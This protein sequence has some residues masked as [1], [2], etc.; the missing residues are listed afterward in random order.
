MKCT[1]RSPRKRDRRIDRTRTKRRKY[2]CS[3]RRVYFLYS[4]AAAAGCLTLSDTKEYIYIYILLNPPLQW[5]RRRRRRGRGRA[6]NEQTHDVAQCSVLPPR[7]K[8]SKLLFDYTLLSDLWNI[9]IRE[10]NSAARKTS[11]ISPVVVCVDVPTVDYILLSLEQS[12]M[13]IK[14]FIC[15][16]LSFITFNLTGNTELTLTHWNTMFDL[17][18][19]TV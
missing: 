8:N 14:Y 2:S 3:K 12:L 11:H 16:I 7:V 18:R 9:Y 19:T 1:V 5:R 15:N 4:A 17:K 6:L 10:Y 13:I